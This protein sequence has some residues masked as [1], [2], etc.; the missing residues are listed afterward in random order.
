M[1]TV[2]G[3]EGDA[4]VGLAYGGV[5]AKR[6]SEVATAPKSADAAHQWRVGVELDEATI[7]VAAQVQAACELLGLDPLNFAN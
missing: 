4:L 3:C 2:C 1:C 6:A 5:R 7:P